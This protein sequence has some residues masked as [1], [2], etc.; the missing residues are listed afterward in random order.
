MANERELYERL[1]ATLGVRPGVTP[2]DPSRGSGFGSDALKVNGRIFAM[3]TGGQL[4]L[5]LPAARVRTLIDDGTGG[6]FDAGKGR[7]MREWLTVL[8][9]DEATWSALAAEAYEFVRGP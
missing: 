7:P 3:L 6:P 4:V 2:P 5:K 1:V 8:T 9:T